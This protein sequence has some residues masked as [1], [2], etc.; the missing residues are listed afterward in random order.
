M[1]ERDPGSG[2]FGGKAG[3]DSGGTRQFH[4]SNGNGGRNGFQF[5]VPNNMFADFLRH[6]GGAGT[7]GELDNEELASVF[8]S[9][10]KPDSAAGPS[11]R[12]PGEHHDQPR[13]G[14]P[15]VEVVERPLPLT[16]E[17]MFRGATKNM[18]IDRETYDPVTGK[19]STQDRIL[20]VPIKKGLLAGSKIKFTDVGD[21]REGV[22][23]DLHFIIIDVRWLGFRSEFSA[24]DRCPIL[25]TTRALHTRQTRSSSQGKDKYSQSL[26]WPGTPRPNIRW[27]RQDQTG[28]S[29]LQ[30]RASQS[31]ERGDLTV[32]VEI[33]FPTSLTPWQK[34]GL[35]RIFEDNQG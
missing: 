3:S 11:L 31:Q 8:G 34:A 19:T 33:D 14:S 27:S 28:R 30:V 1:R 13:I 25:E 9:K 7:D 5:N 32:G 24:T 2:G 10:D 6:S 21:S 35:Q 26:V 12:R 15:E 4:S 29:R 22:T 23:Q 20:E 18:K 16:L 17:E